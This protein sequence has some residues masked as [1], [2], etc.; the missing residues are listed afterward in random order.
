[1]SDELPTAARVADPGIRALYRQENRWQAWLDV[2]AALAKAQAELGIIPAPAAEAIA[3]RRPARIARPRPHRRGLRAHRP[4]DRALGLGIEPG[5]RRAAWRLGALGRDDAEHHADRRSSGVA[6]GASGLPA[7][8]RRGTCRRWPISPNAAPTCR[9]P[10]APTASTRCPATFGYK[11]AVWI[12]EMIR[13]VERFR[14]GGAPASL[15]RCWAAAPA[16]LPRSANRGR[17]CRPASRGSSACS[18][19]QV[20][21]RTIGDHLAENICLL[22]LLAAT[23]SKIGARDLYPDEDRI[24]RGRGAGAARHGRQLDDAAE[25]QPQALPGHHRGRGRG[26]RHR[27]VGAW[28][29]CRPS[30]RPTARRA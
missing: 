15:S 14:A 8:D 4:H 16:P 9:S 29:R 25:A 3:A 1:M 2:E 23:C 19:M 13:H 22:G 20:P 17:R 28:R 11:P 30:T 10:G 26:A 12:D 18:S 21:A 27:A 24:R 6:P 5:R 7:A